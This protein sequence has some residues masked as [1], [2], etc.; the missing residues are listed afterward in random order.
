MKRCYMFVYLF[1]LIIYSR[2]LMRHAESWCRCAVVVAVDTLL[3]F[4]CNNINDDEVEFTKTK[5]AQKRRQQQQEKKQLTKGM[6]VYL[7]GYLRFSF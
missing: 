5:D 3:F 7:Y 4:I 2:S 6:Y 1:I